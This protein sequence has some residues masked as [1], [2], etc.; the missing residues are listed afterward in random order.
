M[1]IRSA[2][3]AAFLFPLV[4]PIS[5]TGDDEL[6]DE[7]HR[8]VRSTDAEGVTSRY[9]YD[10]DGNLIVTQNSNGT[11]IIHDPVSQPEAE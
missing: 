2:V 4:I 3:L 7:S 10:E 8:L 1:H 11:A 6:F 9:V 5:A